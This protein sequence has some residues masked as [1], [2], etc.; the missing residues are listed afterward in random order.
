MAP[1]EAS[2]KSCLLPVAIAAV[3]AGVGV[4]VWS[5]QQRGASA[6]DEGGAAYLDALVAGDWQAAAAADHPV[7]D[8]DAATLAAAW[9]DRER[10]WGDLAG[11]ELHVANPGQDSDG[12]FVRA[13]TILSF[14]GEAGPV[15]LN[16]TLRP[17]GEGYR[18]WSTSPAARGLRDEAVW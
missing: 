12:P 15:P 10:R 7:R 3:M 1:Q 18:V 8:L 13:E 6:L 16:L 17:H 11:W 5:A 9:T 14:A 2:L 4:G